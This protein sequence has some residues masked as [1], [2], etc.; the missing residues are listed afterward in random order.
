[1]FAVAWRNLWRNSTRSIVSI[2]AIAF[3]YALFLVT[4]GISDSSYTKM[5]DAAA[6]SA[7]GSVLIHAPGYWDSRMNDIVMTDPN[8]ALAAV[9]STA[10]VEGSARR[11]LING[12][13][14]TSSG[15][16]ATLIQGVDPEEE[17]LV[18]NAGQYLKEGTFL[19]GDEEDPLVLGSGAA[20]ELNVKIGDRVVLTATNP[21][22]DMERA[23]FH[24]T[25]IIHTGSRQLDDI[26]AYTSIPAAQKSISMAGQLTQI[27]IVA[28]R[29]ARHVVKDRLVGALGD[30]YEIMTWDE[31]MPEM[32]SLIEMDA[33]FANIYGL[34]VF[35]VVVFAV[36]NTFMMIV[37][38]RIREFGLLSAIGLTPKQVAALLV[39]E[40]LLMA[41]V[42]MT[43]GFAVGF[44]IHS[45]IH[46]YGI[47]LTAIYGDVEMGGVVM[48]DWRLRSEV[49]V[50]RWIGATVGVFVL[51]MSATIYPA[52]KAAK[53]T[54]AQAMRF[55]Q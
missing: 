35:L 19:T 42:A 52:Y 50:S 5:E 20:H 16:V 31:A 8:P 26:A 7:G 1:M 44:G 49:N 41:L 25:G 3:S 4:M 53:L 33:A 39:Y 43:I 24:V 30:K 45:Y 18:Q 34:V 17:K 55:F 36:L 38:E 40:S 14:S 51:T 32:V 29:D 6:D 15:N 21:D 46:A 37:M 11:V 48:G 13:L 27:G 23:L 54:P 28:P 47:D 22:G 12:L 10:G 2:S 9:K